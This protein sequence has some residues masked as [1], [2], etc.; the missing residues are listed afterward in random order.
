MLLTNAENEKLKQIA[1]KFSK[2]FEGMGC[3]L[4]LLLSY[5]IFNY[6]IYILYYI[7]IKIDL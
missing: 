2:L 4:S 3:N 5:N 7:Y 1:I 6:I